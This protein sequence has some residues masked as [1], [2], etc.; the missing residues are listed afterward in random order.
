MG[1]TFLLVGLVGAAAGVLPVAPAH[2]QNASPLDGVWTLDRSLSEL[3]REIG[4]NVNWLPSPGGSG[5]QNT[6]STTGG[7]RSRRGSGGGGGGVGRGYTGPSSA[8]RESYEDA[9][10]VQL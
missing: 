5:G 1:R 7:G 4:F 8:Q 2:A 9:R 3:P 10:R 6:G